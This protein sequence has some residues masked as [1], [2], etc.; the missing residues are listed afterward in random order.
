MDNNDLLFKPCYQS[1]KTCNQYGTKENSNCLTCAESYYY[2]Y[3]DEDI[4]KEGKNIKCYQKLD[5]Y[6]LEKNQYF[7]KCYK[8]CDLCEK[9]GN[10]TYHNCIKCNSEYFYELNI[11]SYLNCYNKCKFNYYYDEFNKKYYC[12]P[13]NNCVNY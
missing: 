2:K 12:T 5:G 11:S 9:E 1:C 3:E 8:T 7:K 4:L 10:D 13:D 6:Y